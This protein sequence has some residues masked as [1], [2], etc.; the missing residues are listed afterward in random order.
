MIIL[1]HVIIAFSS[2]ASATRGYI[3][4]TN[5]N[6]QISYALIALTFVSGFMLVWS[7]P[8]QMLRTC[9]SGIVYLAV[10]TAGVLLTRRKVAL[11]QLSNEQI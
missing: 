10:V 1:L 4:P 9:L 5:K 7:E 6:Q 8:A 3:R 11:M 2:I